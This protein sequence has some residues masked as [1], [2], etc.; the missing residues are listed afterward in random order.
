MSAPSVR[1]AG[2]EHAYPD[3]FGRRRERVLRGI[4]LELAPGTVLGL[5]G[6]NGSG[7]STLMRVLAGLEPHVKGHLEVLGGHP[8]DRAVRR[9]LGWL[10][11]DS[12][13]PPELSARAALDLAAALQEV[14][15][16]E[17]RAE[18]ARLL[19]LVGL[20][21]HA[22]KALG[23]Y[24]RGMLRRFGLAQ[25]W[26]ARPE[27]LLLDEPTAGLDAE[28]F[29]VLD[30][31]LAEARARGTTVVLASHLLSDLVGGCDELV[32]LLGGRVAERGRPRDVLGAGTLLDVYRRHRHAHGSARDAAGKAP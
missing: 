11:E 31:V 8:L 32:V 23:G 29:E 26:I 28:G 18:C 10:P 4:D 20:E 19:A 15:R 6:P 7:K 30:Q 22:R 9:R 21:A 24:S 16:A 27:L 12:P 25:A 1:L 17:R 14:P 5:A 13:F 3:F 2:L